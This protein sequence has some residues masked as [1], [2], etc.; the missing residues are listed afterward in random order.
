MRRCVECEASCDEEVVECI[1]CYQPVHRA[2]AGEIVNYDWEWKYIPIY[3]LDRMAPVAYER[4]RGNLRCV[5]RC[6]A[7]HEGDQ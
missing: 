4:H 6:R 2:C 5:V 1:W 3:T 7:C